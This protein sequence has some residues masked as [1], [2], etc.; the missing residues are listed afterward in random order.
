[1]VRTKNDLRAQVHSLIIIVMTISL[2]VMAVFLITRNQSAT[3]VSPPKELPTHQD[4]EG[5]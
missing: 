2:I 3:D 4:V 5:E 1:M